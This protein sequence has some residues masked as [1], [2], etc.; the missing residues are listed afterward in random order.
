MK[1]LNSTQA[2][3][4]WMTGHLAGKSAANMAF[5]DPSKMG[6]VMA[7]SAMIMAHSA[8]QRGV[9]LV[10]RIPD[11]HTR[12]VVS[13]NCAAKKLAAQTVAEVQ[14]ARTKLAKIG[15]QMHGEAIAAVADTFDAPSKSAL[16]PELRAW[17]KA[18]LA[19]GNG[20]AVK[21]ALASD[22]RLAAAIHDAPSFL[23][24]V[25]D[26]VLG[27]LKGCA[28]KAHAPEDAQVKAICSMEIAKLLPKYDAEI[29]KIDRFFYDPH[30]AAK[31]ETRIE[32]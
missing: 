7:Q 20:A 9:N 10:V 5:G 30:Q 18:E 8:I 29:A 3:R 6:N 15:A 21:Q 11:D 31:L 14:S 32:V 17:A 16:A 19:K 28:I 4:D 25:S 27:D 26:D 23:L 13:Q 1:F 2:A 22:I 12:T 24:G